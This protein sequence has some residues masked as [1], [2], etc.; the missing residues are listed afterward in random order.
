MKT[1]NA[2]KACEEMGEIDRQALDG[3]IKDAMALIWRSAPHD[4]TTYGDARDEIIK[5]ISR[6]TSQETIYNKHGEEN[7]N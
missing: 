5:S 1:Y 6:I 7:E 2:P 4:C 3:M